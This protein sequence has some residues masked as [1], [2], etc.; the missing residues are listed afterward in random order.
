M[1]VAKR[2]DPSPYIVLGRFTSLR[3]PSVLAAQ[4]HIRQYGSVVSKFDVYDDFRGFFSIPANAKKIYKPGPKAKIQY[5]H[6]VAVVGYD[7][8]QQFWLAKNSWGTDWGDNGFFRVAYRTCSIVLNDVFGIRWVPY[9]QPQ[10][11]KL[12]VKSARQRGCFWYQARS[13][14]FPSLI[15]WRAGI[16]LAHFLLNNTETIKSLDSPLEGQKILLCNPNTGSI[17]IIR[18]DVINSQLQALLDLRAYI[19]QTGR[20]QSWTWEAGDNDGFCSWQ[21]IKCKTIN[22][23]RYVNIVRIETR[24]GFTG[25][26]GVLPPASVLLGLP[27]L[28]R[29]VIKEQLGI[30]G[31][32][33]NDWS[34]LTT[35]KYLE[36]IS[37][38]YNSLN[39]TLPNSW[40]ELKQLKGLSGSAG[41][42]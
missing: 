19:D 15:A 16:T 33:R 41:P 42:T 8:E 32:L 2:D 6:A 37:L 38:D 12:P 17:D 22:G 9:V 7:N 29:L 1:C 35:L 28:T 36:E 5:G 40:G 10:M 34:Q 13:G 3:L 27:G 31:P 26:V 24:S 18:S 39:G 11:R 20:M 14:D 4:E 21:G 30:T 25:L 23:I